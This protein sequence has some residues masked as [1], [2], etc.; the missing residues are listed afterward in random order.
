MENEVLVPYIATHPGE[1][2]NDELQFRKIKQRDFANNIGMQPTMLNEIIRGKRPIT[3]QIALILEKAL[4]INA[5]YWIR[6]QAQ[7]E[8]D[9]ERIKERTKLKLQWIEQWSFLKQYVP[10]A[11]FKKVGVIVNNL[12]KDIATIKNIYN[13][14]NLE[15][16]INQFAL[17][18]YEYHRKS[19]KSQ[20]T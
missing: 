1:L 4:G 5:D 11:Y 12:S 17:V 18:K 9:T 19:K 6:F 16:I 15:G 14:E 3:A 7:Y 8:L 2:I 10:I 13:V 20:I